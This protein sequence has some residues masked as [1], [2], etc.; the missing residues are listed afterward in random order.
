MKKTLLSIAAGLTILVSGAAFV[1]KSSTGIAGNTGSPGEQTCA[2]CHSGGS[3]IASGATIAAVPV[4]S[5]NTYVP[6]TTYTINIL[7][8]ALSYTSFGFACEILNASNS[9]AGTMQNA[10][11]GVQFVTAG[12][13]RNNATHTA[14]KSGTNFASFSF[15]WVAPASGNVNIFAAGNCVNGNGATSGDLPVSATL[16]LTAATSTATSLDEN[17]KELSGF[18][19]YPNPAKDVLHVN[20]QLMASS[21]VSIDLYSISGQHM[22]NLVNEKQ[23]AGLQSK[24]VFL[25]ANV[26]SGVYFIKATSNGKVMTQKL[27]T[28]Q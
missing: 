3:S 17:T 12:N 6:G 24:S 14:P 7:T 5:N 8:G 16:A 26:A 27:V 19:V 20:Y 23:S 28:I 10:G 22:A 1:S 15:Q 21:A 11:S 9:N 2:Q 18:A 4:F 13:G 25:P